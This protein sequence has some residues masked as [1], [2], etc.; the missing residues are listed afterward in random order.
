M[1]DSLQKTRSDIIASMTQRLS[2]TAQLALYHQLRLINSA[3]EFEKSVKPSR[4][5]LDTDKRG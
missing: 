2:G 4:F 1:K 3:I 5:K